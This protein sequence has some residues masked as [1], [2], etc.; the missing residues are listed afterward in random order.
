[1][2]RKCTAPPSRTRTSRRPYC[3][4]ICELSLSVSA[5]VSAGASFELHKRRN[6]RQTCGNASVWPL[7]QRRVAKGG[8]LLLAFPYSWRRHVGPH[9]AACCMGFPA[10]ATPFFRGAGRAQGR[11]SLDMSRLP[12]LYYHP[13][14]VRAECLDNQRDHPVCLSPAKPRCAGVPVHPTA[15]GREHSPTKEVKTGS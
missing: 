6:A 12:A 3:F 10:V 5:G 15:A 2:C 1:M 13:V 11:N 4:P 9:C 14:W 7:T 8:T